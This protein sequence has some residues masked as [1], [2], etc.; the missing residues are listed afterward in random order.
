MALADKA[1]GGVALVRVQKHIIWNMMA[2]ESGPLVHPVRFTPLVASGRGG[3]AFG[4][5]TV[6]VFCAL[7]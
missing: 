1:D 4:P 2:Q 3:K 6:E 5:L 7:P